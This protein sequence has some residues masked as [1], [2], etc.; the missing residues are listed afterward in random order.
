MNTAIYTTPI[1]RTPRCTRREAEISA[2]NSLIAKAFGVNTELSHR[3]DGAPYI[4]SRPDVCISISHCI[5]ECVLVV[6]D[7]SI[8]VDIETA[9]PML[10]RIA[11]KFLTPAEQD[12][13][14]HTLTVLMQMWSA[15]EAVFKCAGIPSLVVSAIEISSDLTMAT[16]CHDGT[17]R[18]FAL[19]YPRLTHTRVIALAREVFEDT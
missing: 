13:G 14:P 8:G 9:R 18:R 5:D 7:K 10:E 19:T 4:V 3:A 11:T 12:R 17:T 15:K 6:S 1:E 2:I 16:V